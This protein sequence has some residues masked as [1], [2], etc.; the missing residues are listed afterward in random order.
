MRIVFAPPAYLHEQ[1][2]IAPD[3][4]C[5]EELLVAMQKAY[6]DTFASHGVDGTQ[7]TLEYRW[8]NPSGDSISNTTKMLR[9]DSDLQLALSDAAR[10]A[11]TEA[12][13]WLVV[14]LL[15]TERTTRPLTNLLLVSPESGSTATPQT[16]SSTRLK[17]QSKPVQFYEY[18]FYQNARNPVPRNPGY[19]AEFPDDY[20]LDQTPTYQSRDYE[21]NIIYIFQLT[22]PHD[23]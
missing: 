3:T 16:C 7:V 5:F 14:P 18:Y 1:H 17:P 20:S 10:N 12:T 19:S 2:S 11:L 8:A 23:S 13:L 6:C 4:V 15:C 21:K 22:P 9:S